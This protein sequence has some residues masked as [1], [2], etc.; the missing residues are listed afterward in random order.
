MEGKMDVQQP[1]MTHGVIAIVGRG[2]N[3][4]HF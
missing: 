2:T 3:S 1:L 4:Y